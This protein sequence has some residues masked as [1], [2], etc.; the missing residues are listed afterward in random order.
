MRK[1]IHP[2]KDFS[3]SEINLRGVRITIKIFLKLK[4]QLYLNDNV[5]AQVL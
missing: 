5:F 3:I 1:I 4:N 2:S